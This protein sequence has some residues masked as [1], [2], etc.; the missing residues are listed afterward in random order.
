[1]EN[2]KS[3]VVSIQGNGTYTSQ[4]YGLFYKYDVVMENGDAGEVSSNKST[5]AAELKFKVGDIVDY[6]YDTS[7]QYKKIKII[8]PE[9]S[10][11]GGKRPR[12]SELAMIYCNAFTQANALRGTLGFESDKTK[13]QIEALCNDADYIAAHIIKKSGI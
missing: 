7:T 4:K 3:K 8:Y 13:S 11:F 2:K 9:K 5:T 10:S 12:E 6:Q 1:M